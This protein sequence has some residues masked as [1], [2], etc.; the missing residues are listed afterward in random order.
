M[1]DFHAKCVK[2]GK[3]GGAQ[4]LQ[5]GG[6]PL[7][8]SVLLAGLKDKGR[9]GCPKEIEEMNTCAR[10]KLELLIIDA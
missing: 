6:V 8:L 9:G 10:A 4:K 5:N 3:S 2:L 7:G 1:R